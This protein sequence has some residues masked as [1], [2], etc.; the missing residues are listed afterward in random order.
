MR[1]TD[2]RFVYHSAAT[3]GDV[4]NFA[5]RL[6]RYAEQR[7]IEKM[8]IDDIWLESRRQ[9]HGFANVKRIGKA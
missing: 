8:S 2:P 7:R 1:I 6:K 9:L 3:H 4:R 5:E